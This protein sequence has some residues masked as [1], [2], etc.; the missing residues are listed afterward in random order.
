[1]D[2]SH[3]VTGYLVSE[4]NSMHG[5]YG[6][7]FRSAVAARDRLTPSQARVAAKVNLMLLPFISKPLLFAKELDRSLS[8]VERRVLYSLAK[9][10]QV[11]IFQ[12]KGP[13]PGEHAPSYIGGGAP[14][15]YLIVT[16]EAALSAGWIP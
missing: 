3:D 15:H 4:S 14:H 1:M 16:R 13:M 2:L 5:D 8:K 10:G 12:Q 11:R 7:N 9:G 6:V